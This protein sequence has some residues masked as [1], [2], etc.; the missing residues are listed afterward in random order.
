M[1]RY[2][3]ILSLLLLM[4]LIPR[5]SPQVY[6][7]S[8]WL[9]G[10]LYR[11]E[12]TVIEESG[13]GTDFQIN[14]DIRWEK[15][16]DY[17]NT[18]YLNGHTQLDFDDIRITRADS[19]TLEDI[20]ITSIN[21]GQNCSLW[22]EVSADL[23]SD[24]ATLFLY[25]GNS[26]VSSV[27]NI[28]NTFIDVIDNVLIGSHFDEGTGT[29]SLNNGLGEDDGY[30][31][32]LPEDYP[33]WDSGYH[34]DYCLKYDGWGWLRYD[35][36][37][38]Y[39]LDTE[40][41]MVAWVYQYSGIW[42]AIS[43]KWDGSYGILLEIVASGDTQTFEWV[44][45]TNYGLGYYGGSVTGSWHHIASTY[46][47]GNF[48]NIV[49][50]GEEVS[51]R[52]DISGSVDNGS[53]LSMDVGAGAYEWVDDFI[54]TN[55]TITET[56]LNNIF[57]N[58]GDCYIDQ[59]FSLVRKYVGTGSETIPELIVGIESTI[60]GITEYATRGLIIGAIL[61]FSVVFIPMVVVVAKKWR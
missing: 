35:W 34:G 18:I 59:G 12:I 24:N 27:S 44:G 20:Y 13:C 16:T 21:D 51:S 22:V 15:G 39:D 53:N 42:G 26:T 3:V 17:N 33:I 4:V 54:F 10:W 56:E 57:E 2:A 6:A 60:S 41:S 37:S 1:K 61:I 45:S 52:D 55:D 46:S 50:D 9:D 40:W 28:D 25:Y 30:M 14:F 31:V 5:S 8:D 43:D 48:L 29:T 11:R 47:S 58:Y 23:D 36:Q 38:M 49:L 7:Q 32:G 19:E